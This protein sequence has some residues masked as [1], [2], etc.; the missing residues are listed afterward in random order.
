MR[1]SIAW[2]HEAFINCPLSHAKKPYQLLGLLTQEDVTLACELALTRE[3]L[4]PYLSILAQAEPRGLDS[5]EID[6][7]QALK[8]LADK[9]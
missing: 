2:L 5:S 7:S 1:H 9:I 3:S 6:L 4:T 8:A